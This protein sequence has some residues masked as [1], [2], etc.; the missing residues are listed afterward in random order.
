MNSIVF[1]T[2]ETRP[3]H[4]VIRFKVSND[5]FNGLAAFE[6]SAFFVI[7]ALALTTMLNT[8]SQVLLIDTTLTKIDEHIFDRD[9]RENAGL[10]ELL[11]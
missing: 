7:Q 4:T 9:V 11:G 2:L 3:V 8:D 1:G 10:F 5:R 6:W